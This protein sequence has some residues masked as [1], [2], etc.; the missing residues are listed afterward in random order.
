MRSELLF[1]AIQPERGLHRIRTRLV[2]RPPRSNSADQNTEY[3]RSYRLFSRVKNTGLCFVF[4]SQQY[5]RPITG[6][7][8]GSKL[9]GVAGLQVLTR[10][11][12]GT[13]QFSHV[14]CRKTSW[15]RPS[16]FLCLVQCY[17]NQPDYIFT[18]W[19]TACLTCMLFSL[20][21]HFPSEQ[22]RGQ[23]GGHLTWL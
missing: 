22:T 16:N 4:V 1:C 14:S 5:S 10:A 13:S 12:C 7:S 17:F 15:A 6:T 23:P 2:Q 21:S 20:K 8:R 3:V 19:I 9:P 11:D 18:A